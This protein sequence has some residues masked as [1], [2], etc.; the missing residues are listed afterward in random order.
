MG[1][2]SGLQDEKRNHYSIRSTHHAYCDTYTNA[3][4]PAPVFLRVPVDRD[5]ARVVGG[6][7][8]I[9]VLAAPVS[10]AECRHVG[11]IIAIEIL[12]I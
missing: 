8:V 11:V 12:V 5:G 4:M 7:A 10:A 1:T 3:T 6:V 9:A 2:C